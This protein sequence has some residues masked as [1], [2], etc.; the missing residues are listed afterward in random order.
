MGMILGE[1]TIR[2]NGK[3]LKTKAGAVLNPGGYTR[4]QHTGSGKTWGKSRKY[5]PPSIELVIAADEDVDVI[6]IN[7]MENATMT[8][9]GDNGVSYMMTQASTN[10]PATLREDSGDIAATFFGDKVVGI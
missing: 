5:S 6:E 2:A 8:W 9:E 7:A 4:T 10:E 1:V 3:Q